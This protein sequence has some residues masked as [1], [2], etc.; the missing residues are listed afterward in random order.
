MDAALLGFRNVSGSICRH[1][2]ISGGVSAL[3]SGCTSSVVVSCA[4]AGLLV[5][6]LFPLRVLIE[7]DK[8]S[9]SFCS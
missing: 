9:I 5:V 4:L 7:L 3:P 8:L 1:R 6:E 2:T